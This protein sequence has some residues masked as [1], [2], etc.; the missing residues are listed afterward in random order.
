MHYLNEDAAQSIWT[1]SQEEVPE[2]VA[3]VAIIKY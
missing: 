3:R 2:S 1:I